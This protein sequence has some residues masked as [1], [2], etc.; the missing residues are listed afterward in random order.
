MEDIQE[1]IIKRLDEIALTS[2]NNKMYRVVDPR[3]RVYSLQLGWQKISG[4]LYG[5]LFDENEIPIVIDV[6]K[7]HGYRNV[8]SEK[9][10]TGTLFM[11]A[12]N[13]PF[14]DSKKMG[15]LISVTVIFFILLYSTLQFG[16]LESLLELVEEREPKNKET[17]YAKFR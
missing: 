10:K 5:H 7:K 8:R 13:S 2:S 17:F 3:G 11:L 12:A 14:G 1:E 15:Q 16:I 9:D 6:L 4:K